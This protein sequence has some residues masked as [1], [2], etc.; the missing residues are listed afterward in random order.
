MII[1]AVR[2]KKDKDSEWK[3]GISLELNGTSDKAREAEKVITEEGILDT[4]Y[5]LK[6]QITK[7]CIEFN[8]N[9]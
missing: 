9:E 8:T 5:N 2:Y 3:W 7:L 1:K 6:D 4:V